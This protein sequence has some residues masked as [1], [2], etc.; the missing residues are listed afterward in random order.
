MISHSNLFGEFI[1]PKNTISVFVVNIQHWLDLINILEMP[2][3]VYLYEADFFNINKDKELKL[4]S[5][6]VQ[7]SLNMTS[8]FT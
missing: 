4:R 5:I 6:I 2:E 1:I 3:E 7:N 8:K